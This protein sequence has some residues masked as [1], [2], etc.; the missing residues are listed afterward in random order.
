MIPISRKSFFIRTITSRWASRGEAERF[1]YY[2]GPTRLRSPLSVSLT[3]AGTVKLRPTSYIITRGLPEPARF[4]ALLE[5]AW[6]DYRWRSV[7]ARVD[8]SQTIEMRI[9]GAPPAGDQPQSP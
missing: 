8:T 6:S 7:P 4:G 9:E 3:P 5:G 2:D 1:L